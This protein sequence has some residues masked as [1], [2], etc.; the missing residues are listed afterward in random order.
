M[1]LKPITNLKSFKNLK[2][3]LSERFFCA[4]FSNKVSEIYLVY[5]IPSLP[6]SKVSL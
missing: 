2:T 1:P 4:I 6:T 5:T 3:L